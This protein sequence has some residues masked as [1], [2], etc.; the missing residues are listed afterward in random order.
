MGDRRQRLLEW[1]AHQ[2][3]QPFPFQQEV[4]DAY[5]AGESGLIHSPTGTG[6]SLAAWG[7]P[8]LEEPPGD[9]LRVLWI[10][11]LRA[12]AADTAD[13]LLRPVRELDLPWTVETR[14]GDTASG[15]KTR[16]RRNLPNAL[17]TTPESLTLMLSYEEWQQK[18]ERLRLVVVDE[19]HELLSSKRGVQ[20]ELA[21][22]RL[23]TLKPDLRTWGVSATLGNLE[24]AMRTL[25]GPVADGRLV[26]GA[27]GKP[28][29]IETL[30]PATIARFP[31]AGHMG[32]SMIPRVVEALESGGTCLVFTNTR[33]MAEIWFQAIL[34]A[35][36][37]WAEELAL[38]HGSLDGKV[39][40]D[41]EMGLKEGRLRAVVCTSSLD[42]GVDFTPVDRV[43]QVGSPKGV[44]RLLQ[45]AGRSG[46]RPGVPSRITCVPTH[47]LELIDIAAAKEAARAGR[48]EEREPLSR[49]LDVLVQHLVTCALGGGFREEELREE[50]QRTWS[51]R[52]L[53]DG[54]WRWAL[55]FV[56]RGG[57][58]LQAYPEYRRVVV[59]DGLH[60]VEER[61][62]ALRHRMSVG[63]IVSDAA[64]AVQYLKGARLGSVEESFLA[65]LKP[66]DRF[67]FAGR[68]L[69]FVR[70]RDMTAWVRRASSTRGA[71]PRWLGGR[72]PLSHQLAQAIRE[73][74]DRAKGGELLSEEM[75]LLAPI[76][77]VQARWSSIP[78]ADELLVEWVEDREGHHLFFFPFE[79]RLVHQGLAALLAYRLSKRAPITFTM[80]ANDY[81][82]ELLSAEAPP[83]DER[84]EELLTADDLLVD[85]ADSLNRAELARR[86][87]REIARVAGLVFQGYPG[88]GKTAR[89]LQASSGLL[90][91]VFRR[92]DP[93][94]LLLHQADREVLEKQ[95]EQT[96]LAAAL[97]RL[98]AATKVVTR[99]QRFTPLAFPI[100]V[101]RLRETVSSENVADRIEKLA[102]RLE[103]AAG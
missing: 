41:V 3:W 27:I 70:M 96:R 20:A 7:G 81:G 94:N 4:W 100:M 9:G 89:Q 34:E 33:A 78:G 95:L 39:R 28:I 46:H 32:V 103:K 38:H 47:A 40:A 57:A 15:T 53:S 12:L 91:D 85:I 51:Y 66:G 73:Q 8:L 59:R 102:L 55:D 74:L 72:L 17:V 64:V 54:E 87:F 30:F 18:F 101:D 21:L 60:V 67:L 50:V 14:T 90:Y 80:A 79:G 24:E 1:F 16:Q 49:P 26:Q 63:T 48:I 98:R 56:T 99:P 10:T 84:M 43:I 23:R 29:E 58:S 68:P 13:T 86:Q 75:R 61:Q 92:Y 6:K 36:P 5:L 52:D 42:L 97:A 77:E 2:G 62:V 37:E 71:V 76:L 69:E 45:R 88:A 82:F 22:A 35:R 11:P 19:W 25:M 31:W 65:R 83:F 93:E 44:A